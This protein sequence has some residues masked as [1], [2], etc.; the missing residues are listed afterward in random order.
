VRKSYAHAPSQ[1]AC[2]ATILL[3]NGRSSSVLHMTW[4][5]ARIRGLTFAEE[6]EA[7]N[8]VASS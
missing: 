5:G 4:T 8:T 2:R 1:V 3:Q 7:M 6:A